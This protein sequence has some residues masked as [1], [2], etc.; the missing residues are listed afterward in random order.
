MTSQSA[1]ER[2]DDDDD[3]DEYSVSPATCDLIG[4]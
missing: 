3:D 1:D 4:H 2:D